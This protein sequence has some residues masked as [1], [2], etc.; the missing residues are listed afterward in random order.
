MRT[1]SVDVTIVNAFVPLPAFVPPANTVPAPVPGGS[2]PSGEST[3]GG[4]ANQAPADSQS[5]T[6]T[7]GGAQASLA[8]MR[9][10][11]GGTT[12]SAGNQTANVPIA[13]PNILWGAAA[14]AT[15]GA[16]LAE[17]QRRREEEEAARR[18][19]MFSG[20]GGDEEEEAS[21]VSAKKRAKVM[22]KN[23]AKRNQE[24]AWENARVEK[25]REQAMQS[26]RQ[27]EKDAVAI[28]QAYQAKKAMEAQR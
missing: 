13:N 22:A 10:Q 25:Q 14:A 21:D 5:T 12:F 7:E 11:A 8:S 17:W 19:A 23:Q 3:F 4:E 26:H 2:A 15:L 9:L 16:T 6:V 20:G 27:G 18:A 24:Q 28:A 1:V